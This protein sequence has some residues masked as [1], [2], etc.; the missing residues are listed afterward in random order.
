MA[1]PLLRRRILLALAATSGSLLLGEGAWR[2]WRSRG[3]GPTSNPHYVLH[4]DF[5]GWRY[6]P[7]AV[8]RHR[9]EEF[10]VEIRIDERG[11]RAA[12]GPAAG[13][14][15]P[16]ILALGD[17]VTFGWGVEGGETFCARLGPLLGA[18]VANLGVS[19]YGTDQ[20]LLLFEQERLS[21]RPRL[22][23]LMYWRNDI[24]EVLS[25][26]AYGKGKPRFRLVGD[27][28][29]LTNV[30]VPFPFWERHS[31]LFRSIKRHLLEAVSSQPGPAEIPEGRRLVR[32]LLRR[33]DGAAREAGA[34]LL[35]LADGE[36]WLDEPFEDGVRL[37]RLDVSGALNR[38]GETAG[39]TFP[40]DGHWNARGH[41]AVAEAVAS[42]V[43]AEGLLP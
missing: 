16:R 37:R 43:R 38:A 29:E 4:D 7:G 42:Y 22:V 23:L 33:M 18:E 20:E 14:G 19:G 11:F 1:G 28:L 13:S 5:L 15:G 30:P 17:S 21:R 8:A 26:T 12:P 40:R 9:S 34:T 2:L 3:Y 27:D 36:P 31:F 10:D 6:R 32:R 41:A 25:S 39:V 35:V 24:E